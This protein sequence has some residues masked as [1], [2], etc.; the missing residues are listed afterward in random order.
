MLI[1]GLH[2]S[3]AD[4]AHVRLVATAHIVTRDCVE[5]YRLASLFFTNW[6][7]GDIRKHKMVINCPYLCRTEFICKSNQFTLGF[8]TSAL[9]RRYKIYK[10]TC[11]IFIN[12]VLNAWFNCIEWPKNQ[13]IGNVLSFNFSVS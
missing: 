12:V 10:L 2:I 9:N 11:I 7:E 8:V 6:P 1:Q 4:T 3:I 5:L 13:L